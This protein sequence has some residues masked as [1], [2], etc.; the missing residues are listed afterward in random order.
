[1]LTGENAHSA[2]T[3]NSSY[4]GGG[5]GD[6]APK[7]YLNYIIFDEAFIPYDFGFNQISTSALETGAGV[8]RSCYTLSG[9]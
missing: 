5:Y 4:F 7:A 2:F 3:G 9:S 1:M 8:Y 6:D